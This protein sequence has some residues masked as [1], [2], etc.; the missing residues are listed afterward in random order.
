MIHPFSFRNSERELRIDFLDVG[1]GDAALVTM[2]DG[3]TLL[4]DGG[5]R[6]KFSRQNSQGNKQNFQRDARSIGD[7]VVSEYLWW[8]GLHRVDYLLATHADADHMEGLN[9]VAENFQVRAA[10]VART[11]ATD[12]EFTEFA[13]TLD[14]NGIALSLD[15][16]GRRFTLRRGQCHSAL[17]ARLPPILRH[18]HQTTTP[19]CCKFSS[20]AARYF[21]WQTS[22]AKRSWVC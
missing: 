22:S 1:Q 13:Q 11:P 7:A 8:R 2:P 14:K 19:W 12:Q 9:D 18:D 20:A 15:R 3:T 16:R 4:I 6:P 5:G 17:A 21:Y 10:L